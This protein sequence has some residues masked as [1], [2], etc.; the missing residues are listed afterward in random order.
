MPASAATTGRA[1]ASLRAAI[2]FSAEVSVST[3]QNHAG[4]A[5]ALS[6]SLRQWPWS[7]RGGAEH[8][9]RAGSQPGPRPK[10]RWS[11]SSGVPASRQRSAPAGC[12]LNTIQPWG[13]GK[14]GI[15]RASGI[16]VDDVMV[17][18]NPGRYGPSGSAIV[19]S[20][21]RVEGAPG[22][23]FQAPPQ[24]QCL[25]ISRVSVSPGPIMAR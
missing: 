14:F 3:I 9:R 18:R 13:N 25:V 10:T 17:P 2:I 23:G 15:D 16:A 20:P 12:R 1:A 5:S 19:T 6:A 7:C 8:S 24:S 4:V 22:R 11:P 21:T